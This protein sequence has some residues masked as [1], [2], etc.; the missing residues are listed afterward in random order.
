[1]THIKKYIVVPFVSPIEK[2][3]EN[4]IENADKK[5][6]GAI[7]DTKMSDDL[8]MKIYH[9]NLNKFL[10]KYDPNTYGVTPMLAKLA[11]SVTDFIDQNKEQDMSIQSSKV[12]QE[13]LD[14]PIYKNQFTT[15][16]SILKN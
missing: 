10:L 6:S 16:S 11:Q 7:T 14:S 8:K 15:P 2:P 9:Q 3:F 5:M 4:F 13:I 12:K 1:M